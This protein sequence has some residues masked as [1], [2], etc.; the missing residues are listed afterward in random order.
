[1]SESACDNWMWHLIN[2]TYVHIGNSSGELFIKLVNQPSLW[3]LKL[4]K[5][6]SSFSP[7]GPLQLFDIRNSRI[8]HK[9]LPS[10]Q[11]FYLWKVIKFLSFPWRL[12]HSRWR[13]TA[14]FLLFLIGGF[15]LC[16][17]VHTELNCAALTPSPLLK[18][19]GSSTEGYIFKLNPGFTKGKTMSDQLVPANYCLQV[20]VI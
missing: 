13:L 17:C 11:F 15:F 19:E 6:V 5:L 16:V 2:G 10:A 4:K 9:E 14:C 7:P 20:F 8:F 1:M 3:I 12:V 18:L